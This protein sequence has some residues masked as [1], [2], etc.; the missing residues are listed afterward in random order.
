VSARADAVRPIALA[1]Y[2][3]AT[4]LAFPHEVPGIG[5][6]DLG[7][8]L[9]WCVPGALVVGIE[10]LSVR[11]AGWLAFLASLFGH[12]LL[13]HWFYVVTVTYGGMSPW[14]GI[15]APLLPALYVSIFT[16]LFAMGWARLRQ[17][18]RWSMLFGAALWV[19]V[20]WA[21][22]H[23]MGGFPWATLGYALHLDVPLLALTRFTGVYGLSFAAAMLGIALAQAWLDR[24]RERARRLAIVASVIL[25]AHGLG[26]AIQP[27]ESEGAPVVRIAA[28]QGN[29]DQGEKW[30][31]ARRK[32]ILEKY[33]RASESAVAQGAEW[34]VWPETAVPGFLELEP[35][36]AE[37]LAL[38]ARQHEVAL[39]VG[40]MGVR[41]DPS[42]ERFEAFYDSAF[43]FDREGEMIDRYDKTHLVPFGEYVPLRG[44]LGHFFEA[45]ATGLS[46]TDVTPGARPRVV[47]APD[48]SG[49]EAAYRVAVPICY[50][51]LFPHVMRGFGE[52]GAGVML[53]ITNDAW[54]GRTGAPHQFLAMTAMRAAENGRWVVRA[55]NTGV[56]AIIDDLGRVRERSAL[57]EDAVVLAEVPILQE[58]PRTF[59]ARVGDVFAWV[60]IVF[61]LVGFG[62]D[63]V[64]G[65]RQRRAEKRVAG[66]V[67]SE[68]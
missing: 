17:A 68:A 40:G 26:F 58:R 53:A 39:F 54:Y 13:F 56:S 67:E 42:G 62:C 55:A 29:I 28:V 4:L 52:D 7:L 1:C 35:I 10:G 31:E 32:Q 11:R 37:R 14:L 19:A 15:L 41:V 46:S 8:I 16:A 24:G 48:R 25:G 12:G 38:F 44:I 49:V 21:R 61:V 34:V 51:L 20:D 59:Y 36:M 23:F 6:L 43:V 66:S 18:G 5:I 65:R 3:L 50:E 22:A 9:A 30:S 27:S 45:L 2:G 33:L 60:C 47:T 63:R 64:V 57:F